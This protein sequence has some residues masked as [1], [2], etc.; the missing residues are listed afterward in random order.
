MRSSKREMFTRSRRKSLGTTE[1][2]CSGNNNWPMVTPQ[3]Q[4]AVRSDPSLLPLAISRTW[5]SSHD[6]DMLL[7]QVLPAD[8]DA[9]FQ[10][11]DFFASVQQAEPGLVVW[12]RLM[13]LGQTHRVAP[14][15]SFSR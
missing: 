8:Q 14:F 4:L 10:A 9:Y 2:F 7:N 15:I 5:R 1:T 6:V 11:L 13:S 3:I 12:Q